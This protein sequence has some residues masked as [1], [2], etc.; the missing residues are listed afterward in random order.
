MIGLVLYMT[1]Q[2]FVLVPLLMNQIKKNYFVM[3]NEDDPAIIIHEEDEVEVSDHNT[4]LVDSGNVEL[5]LYS[6]EEI[7]LN[8]I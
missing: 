5:I 2:T 4:L 6:V 3:N 7:T 8:K 1:I